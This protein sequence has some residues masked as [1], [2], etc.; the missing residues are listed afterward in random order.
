MVLKGCREDLLSVNIKNFLHP[1]PYVGSAF[2]ERV[3]ILHTSGVMNMNTEKGI[4][5]ICVNFIVHLVSELQSR[6][7]K[8]V[9]VLRKTSSIAPE[10]CLKKIKD[11]IIPLCLEMGIPQSMLSDLE[12]RWQ[13]MNF[14]GWENVTDTVLFWAEV[15]KYRDASKENPFREH[16]NLAKMV[17][18][19]ALV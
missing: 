4:I 7:P 6:V 15:S 5:K 2:E 19:L 12:F 8:N 3:W 13:K 9:E 16:C 11:S 14:V 18:S 17:F 1:K 10:N